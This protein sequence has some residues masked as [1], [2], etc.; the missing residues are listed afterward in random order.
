MLLSHLQVQ[1]LGAAMELPQLP[2]PADL[3]TVQVLTIKKMGCIF[4]RQSLDEEHLPAS[5]FLSP[6]LPI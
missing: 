2:A 3:S 1:F 5:F 6:K 4:T